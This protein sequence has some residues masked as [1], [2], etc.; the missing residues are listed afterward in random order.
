MFDLR[1]RH[2]RDAPRSL[3][4]VLQER[5]GDIIAIAGAVLVRMRRAHAV[6]AVI[7]DAPGQDG[8]PPSELDFARDRIGSEVLLY[9]FEQSARSRIGSC[10]PA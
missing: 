8:G 9:R 10:S 2:A 5:V 6:A 3:L 7:V 1:R 4:S